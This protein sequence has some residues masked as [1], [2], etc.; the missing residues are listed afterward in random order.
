MIDAG[1]IRT[2][3]GRAVVPG[4]GELMAHGLLIQLH[5]DQ[6]VPVL[7]VAGDLD[8]I[9][10]HELLV[11][12]RELVDEAL[13]GPV[14]PAVVVLDASRVAF[15]DSAGLGALVSLLKRALAHRAGFSIAGSGPQLRARL[16]QTGLDR[17]VALH[18]SA[19]EAVS[20]AT[21]RLPD[22]GHRS[23]GDHP[24]G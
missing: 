3:T 19:A 14:E 18:S 24:G 17:V 6:G 5:V 23:G 15:V 1:G 7:E 9:S 16:A 22:G 11:Q 2:T 13:A 4:E 21:G 8:L 10:A 20:A 12:G